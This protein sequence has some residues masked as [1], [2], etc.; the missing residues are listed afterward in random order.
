MYK[1]YPTPEEAEAAAR[2][3]ALENGPIIFDGMNCNDYKDEDEVEC[4][5][6]DGDDRRCNC[7]NR[8]VYWE[9]S[10]TIE[11]RFYASAVAY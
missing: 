2:Q 5:G 7:G 11:G 4:D 1:N 3:Y 10:K 8:R 9:I 6:W